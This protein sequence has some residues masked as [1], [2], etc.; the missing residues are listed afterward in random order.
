MKKYIKTRKIKKSTKRIL[1]IIIVIP[2]IIAYNIFFSFYA[3]REQNEEQVKLFADDIIESTKEVPMEGCIVFSLITGIPVSLIIFNWIMKIRKL[4]I[5]KA[6]FESINDIEYFR[7]ILSDITPIEI[8]LLTDLEVEDKKDLTALILKYYKMGLIEFDNNNQIKVL[9][10]SDELLDSDR[11]I[12]TM[13]QEGCC[14]IDKLKHTNW[15]ELA[16]NESINGRYLRTNLNTKINGAGFLK[17]FGVLFVFIIIIFNLMFK[18]GIE[19][20]DYIFYMIPSLYDGEGLVNFCFI[21]I[22]TAI[23]FLL[24]FKTPM[25]FLADLLIE[26]KNREKYKRTELGEEVTEYLYG[27]KN[28][29]NN[30]S[31][32]SEKDKEAIVLW[33]DFLIYAV[34]L[35]E[36]EKIVDEIWKKSKKVPDRLTI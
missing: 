5:K 7:D 16:I 10:I 25:L 2:L 9:K 8:S 14:N 19:I 17:T 26:R 15:K 12:L 22:P 1:F 33:E 20:L 24:L 31:L 3:F 30:F 29:I 23:L 35:E 18:Y 21:A 32:L 34:L 11:Q 4:N 36:N 6:Q 27:L 13:I 28:F